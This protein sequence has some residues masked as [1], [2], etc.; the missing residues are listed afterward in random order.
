M[1]AKIEV[2]NLQP[3]DRP[4][5]VELMA[6]AFQHD[7]LFE[8][9]FGIPNNPDAV[10]TFL[11]FMFDMTRVMGAKPR[12]AWRDD[13]LRGCYL[14]EPP[15]Q[16]KIANFARMI[17][18]MIRFLPVA[19]KLPWRT[20]RFLNIYMRKTRAEAPKTPHSYLTMIGV[21]PGAQGQG[22]GRHLL[23]D[24]IDRGSDIALDTEANE[25]VGLYEHWGFSLS[26]SIDVSGITAHCMV[27]RQ[28]PVA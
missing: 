9:A 26:R 4:A 11:S 25:N 28:E 20:V 6:A 8:K 17:M 15:T 14:M 27:R 1:T 7:P 3:S 22:I 12:G 23:Q 21:R 16:G 13:Q 24:A 10:T 18:V 5:F 19:V 2:R